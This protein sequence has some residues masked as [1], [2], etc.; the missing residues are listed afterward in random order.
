M[1]FA[2]FVNKVSHKN[3]NNQN[4]LDGLFRLMT[5]GGVNGD[6]GGG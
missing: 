1:H 4:Q 3:C 2:K 5:K 6:E